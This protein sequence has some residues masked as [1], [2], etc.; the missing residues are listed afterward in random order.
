MILFGGLFAVLLMKAGKG[1]M[2]EIS[3]L[4]I[5]FM[6][7][8]FQNKLKNFLP[9]RAVLGSPSVTEGLRDFYDW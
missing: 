5:G 7:P 2:T 8:S 9:E 4:A 3:A 1:V 6:A